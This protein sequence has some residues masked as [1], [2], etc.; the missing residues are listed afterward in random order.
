MTTNAD[1]DRKD[2]ADFQSRF[3]G[4]RVGV[5]EDPVTGSAHCAL[6]PYWSTIL[7]KR[8][9]KAFQSTPVRGGYLTLELPESQPGRVLIKG[10]GVIVLRGSLTSSP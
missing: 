1:P 2:D 3:F 6:T 8:H 5:D 10:E 9:L 7:G 4:P